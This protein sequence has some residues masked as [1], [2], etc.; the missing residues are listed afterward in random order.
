ME[1]FKHHAVAFMKDKNW[2][3]SY[4]KVLC[5]C[6]RVFDVPSIVGHIAREH[7]KQQKTKETTF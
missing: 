2:S 6:G 5:S 1:G 7:E 3:E 4:D